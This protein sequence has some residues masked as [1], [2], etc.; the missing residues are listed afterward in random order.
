M[1]VSEI[2]KWL[3]EKLDRL[4]EECHSNADPHKTV[5]NSFLEGFNYALANVQGLE[6]PQLNEN[7][8]IKTNNNLLK[9]ND[10]A[11]ELQ[12]GAVLTNEQWEKVEK[13]YKLSLMGDEE[14]ELCS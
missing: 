14:E 4:A 10:L 8:Q 9:I 3:E 5:N 6:Q 12:H 2:L 7:Q 13:I 11:F 1:N